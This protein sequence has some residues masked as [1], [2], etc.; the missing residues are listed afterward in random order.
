MRNLVAILL[1]LAAPAALVAGKPNI[2]LIISDQHFA[3]AMSCAG[4]AY[5]KTP[6]LD[7]IAATGVRFRNTYCTYPVCTSSRASLM[8]GLWPHQLKGMDEEAEGK[9]GGARASGRKSRE[10][11][12]DQ[13][14]QPGKSLGTLMKEAGYRTAYF[15]KWHVGGVSSSPDNRWHGFDTLVDGRRDEAAGSIRGAAC[16]R[17]TAGVGP[18]HRGRAT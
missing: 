3:D 7:R 16:Q 2:V 15:G 11:G 6:A 10:H 12:A 1:I 13:A 18:A 14:S 4:Y 17:R 9:A 8:T 5:V